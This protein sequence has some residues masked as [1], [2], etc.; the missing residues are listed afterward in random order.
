MT[1]PRNMSYSRHSSRLR[2]LPIP[3]AFA[4]A[5]FGAY[6]Y[7]THSSSP[8][9]NDTQPLYPVD[10]KNVGL[11]VRPK[12]AGKTKPSVVAAEAIAQAG[13][14]AVWVWGNNRYVSGRPRRDLHL[15]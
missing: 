8:I 14:H 13:E 4:T 10:V 9:R 12:V 1:T 15:G 5:A 3:V 11:E 2:A 6:V 7:Y